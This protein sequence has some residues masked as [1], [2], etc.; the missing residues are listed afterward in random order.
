M[1]A[2]S[3]AHVGPMEPRFATQPPCASRSSRQRAA[4]SGPAPSQREGVSSSERTGEDA[5]RACLA[6]E[7]DGRGRHGEPAGRALLDG[8]LQGHQD[9]A[10]DQGPAR[11]G[12]ALLLLWRRRHADD[13]RAGRRH[14]RDRGRQAHHALSDRPCRRGAPVPVAAAA[15]RPCAARRNDL[16]TGA[17]DRGQLQLKARHHLR[18]LRGRARRGEEAPQA[19]HPHGLSR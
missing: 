2:A 14:Q 13:V 18:V 11:G 17:L 16:W 9:A 1:D 10:V 7:D 4:S 8:A 3:R 12:R 6:G 5:P 19:Q 15:G